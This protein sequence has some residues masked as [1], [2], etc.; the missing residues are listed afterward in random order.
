[1]NLIDFPFRHKYSYDTGPITETVLRALCMFLFFFRG[2]PL[3]TDPLLAVHLLTILAPAGKAIW[4][5]IQR[6]VR[7]CVRK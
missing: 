5:C 2:G 1:L 7:V 6:A 3:F 4:H